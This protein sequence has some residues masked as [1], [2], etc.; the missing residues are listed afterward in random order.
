M[1][2]IKDLSEYSESDLSVLERR[3]FS[4]ELFLGSASNSLDVESSR[5]VPLIETISK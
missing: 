1:E 4:L 2:K 5:T 3:I